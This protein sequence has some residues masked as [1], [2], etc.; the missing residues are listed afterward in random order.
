MDRN[1]SE[2]KIEEIKEEIKKL[3]FSLKYIGVTLTILAIMAIV[4]IIDNI[5]HW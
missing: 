4:D 3:N 1:A 2:E 5:M